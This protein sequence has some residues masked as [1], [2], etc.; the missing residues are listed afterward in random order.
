M[1]LSYSSNKLNNMEQN[2]VEM[3]AQKGAKVQEERKLSYEDLEKVAKQLSIQVQTLSQKLQENNMELTFKRLDYLFAV[4]NCPTG[5]FNDV[6]VEKCV[7][8]IEEIMTPTP[9]EKTE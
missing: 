5:V 8:E 6:F 7:K 9:E 3:K 4:A 1:S 2:K